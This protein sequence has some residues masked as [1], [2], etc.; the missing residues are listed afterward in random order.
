MTQ[1]H[2]PQ[3]CLLA[4]APTAMPAP[5][6][7]PA[8]ELLA[9]Y[10]A[11]F[12]AAWAH[13]AE[14]AGPRRLAD[15][16]AFLP[17]ALSLQETPVHPA[18]RRVAWTIMALFVAA[19]AWSIIGRIDIVA[20]APGRII[21]SDR[22][23]VVQPLERSVVR[24]ILVKDGD[25]VQAGQPL[26]ELDPTNAQ[27]DKSSLREALKEAQSE[28]LRTRAL[29]QALPGASGAPAPAR[30]DPRHLPQGWG[31]PERAQ[32]QAQL[33]AEWNDITARLAR[34][35]AEHQRRQAEMATVQAMIAK[36]E[37]TLPIARQREKDIQALAEQGYAPSHAN[38]DRR[39]ERIELERD[40]ATQQARLQETR[41][42]LL[43][44]EHSR[45]AFL[46]ETRRTLS[47]RQAQA[48]L[49]RHQT[50]Q[51]LAKAT[52]RER[53]ATLTAPVTGTVQ[54]L[55]MHTEGGVVTEAQA[56]LVVVP[57]SAQV[58]AEVLLDN[59]DIGFVAPGQE[60]AV[61][62]ETFLFT[63]YGTVPAVVEKV[64]QDAVNDEKRGAIFP[65]TVKLGRT[66]IDVDG[67]P[68]KLAPGMNVTAEI[69]TGKRR[70]IEYLLSPI[71]RMGSESLRE[72]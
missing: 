34:L 67:R 72:R 7:H 61:K 69:K 30:L 39:R 41:A 57:D 20:V 14:L 52:Q 28:W 24:R 59:K 38:Q 19:L 16:A 56:L 40:L 50:G 27:A 6:R 32:A 13:R 31:A 65:V 18:P 3:S 62:L 66:H 51:E 36:L 21:V 54:Q 25:H 43:E 45:S 71:Q 42:A 63:R 55:A 58:H 10:R 4:P 47:E 64:T 35:A 15:E 26:V 9:R 70:V 17:A 48:D 5:P 44:T 12:A 37:S 49:K 8:I 33:A 11:V 1:H 68:V 29:Q 60:V 22:T 2:A 46:A 53:L 23:K